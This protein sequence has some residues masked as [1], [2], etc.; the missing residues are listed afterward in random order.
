VVT[1]K[2]TIDDA[3]LMGFVGT[4]VNDL[5]SALSC[6]LVV[7]GDKLGRYRAMADGIPVTA[8]ELGNRTGAS[9]PYV[10]DWLVN[11]AAGGYSNSSRRQGTTVCRP[12]MRSLSPMRTVQS[13]WQA[14]FSR[15]RR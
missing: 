5:G 15:S 10:Q 12:S 13:P 14:P 7:I 11:Q 4:V 1:E 9:E 6:A 8:A 3:K 2:V